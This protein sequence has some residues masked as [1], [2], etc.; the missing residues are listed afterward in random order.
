MTGK[1]EPSDDTLRKLNDA[2]GGIF[3]INYL[4]G[5]STV[6]LIE[7][8]LHYNQHPEHS[9]WKNDRTHLPTTRHV[10]CV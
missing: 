3:N 9:L 7:D 10:K 8:E 6:M 4:R 2:F 5:N 1:V